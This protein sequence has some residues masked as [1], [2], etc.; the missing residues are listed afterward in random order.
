MNRFFCRAVFV[1]LFVLGSLGLNEARPVEKDTLVVVKNKLNFLVIGDWGRAG[2]YLQRETGIE[3]NNVS[4]KIDPS[5]IISTGDNFYEQGVA[6][7]DDPQWWFSFENVYS[8]ANL[9][10]NWYAVLGNHDYN[11]SAKAQVDYSKKSRRWRMPSYYYTVE[12]SVPMTKKKALFIFLDTN[13][14]E[15]NYY[16]RPEQYPE[17]QNHDPQKQLVWLD[18][19]LT[20]SKADWKFVI[21]HHHVFT[22]GM[23]K[24]LTSEAGEI[25]KPILERY[26]IDAYICGH[27]HDLQHLKSDGN[28]NYFISGAGSELRNT[29]TIAE[30]KFAKSVNGFMAFSVGE[31]ETLVQVIDY[32]GSVIYK[33]VVKK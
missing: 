12:K 13:Q 24:G 11:G 27:E 20:N 23:R 25:L 18:S 21:G 8:G 26:S 29:G 30:T 1:I 2:D 32:T 6:S 3:L 19:V 28:V 15:K 5:F 22:G 10:I 7:I 33:T 9:F 16:K 17:L 14:F 4:K 31:N